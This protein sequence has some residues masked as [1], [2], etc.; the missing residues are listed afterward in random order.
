M[1]S[2]NAVGE[3]VVLK[4]DAV[5]RV[6]RSRAQREQL[7]D[8]F[9]RSGLSGTKFA[10]LAGIKYQTF[11]FWAQRRRQQRAADGAAKVPAASADKVRWLEAV[12]EQAQNPNRTRTTAL[13]LQLPGGARLEIADVQQAVLAAAFVRALEHPATTC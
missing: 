11:A 6:K 7:L 5:G 1:T 10:A 12:V 2:T 13:V 8:E 9:E 4:S 3:A